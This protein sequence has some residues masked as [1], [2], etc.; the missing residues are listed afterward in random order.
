MDDMIKRAVLKQGSHIRPR[1]PQ[2]GFMDRFIRAAFPLALNVRC[3]EFWRRY[4]ADK[5]MLHR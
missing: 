2:S 1:P 5:Q 4:M 3:Q